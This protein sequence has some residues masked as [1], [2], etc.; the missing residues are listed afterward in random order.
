MKLFCLKNQAFAPDLQ[1]GKLSKSHKKFEL[2]DNGQI[3]RGETIIN[4]MQLLLQIVN[5]DNKDTLI[6]SSD[7]EKISNGIKKS[8]VLAN[9]PEMKKLLNTFVK[10]CYCEGNFFAIPFFEGFSLNTAK[11]KLKQGGY[12]YIFVDSSDTYFN[13]CYNFFVNGQSC[14]QITRLIDEKYGVWKERYLNNG[15]NTFVTDN[16]FQ[17][18]MDFD[19]RPLRLWNKTSEGFS[20]DLENYLKSAI[21][22]LSN[23]EKRIIDFKNERKK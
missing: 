13:V 18:F 10:K 15:W 4:C 20:I 16:Y 7:F 6:T 1:V 21:T 11:G 2:L 8:S 5:Y 23:R 3:Y 17:D 9:N 19:G 12:G 14:C 22:V